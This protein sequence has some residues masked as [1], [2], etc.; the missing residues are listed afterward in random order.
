MAE[1]VSITFGLYLTGGVPD[2]V[3]LWRDPPNASASP[4]SKPSAPKSPAS[5]SDAEPTPTATKDRG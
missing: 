3:P 5:E 1:R 2:G 4:T